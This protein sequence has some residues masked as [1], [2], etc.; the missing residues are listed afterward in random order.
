VGNELHRCIAAMICRIMM[1][2][3]LALLSNSDL[4]PLIKEPLGVQG[5]S[6]AG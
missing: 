6:I 5:L 2:Q 4:P 3:T 1:K